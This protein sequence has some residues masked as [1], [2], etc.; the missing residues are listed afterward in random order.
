[1]GTYTRA[2]YVIGAAA[3]N[4]RGECVGPNVVLLVPISDNAAN[5]NILVCMVDMRALE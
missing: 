2:S 4:M 1:M 5:N 3:E